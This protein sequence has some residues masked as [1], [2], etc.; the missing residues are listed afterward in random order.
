M[1]EQHNPQIINLIIKRHWL[2]NEKTGTG[3][4]KISEKHIKELK[5][6]M[7]KQSN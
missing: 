1:T 4:E 7:R 5:N 6:T 2:W 3:L